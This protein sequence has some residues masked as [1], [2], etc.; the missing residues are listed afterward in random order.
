MKKIITTLLVAAML[1]SMAACGNNTNVNETATDS[2][3][4]E[5][6]GTEM[7]TEITGTESVS[8][9]SVPAEDGSF[10]LGDHT[11]G[12]YLLSEFQSLMSENPAMS[13]QEI[14]DALCASPAISLIGPVT[15]AMEEG[16]LPG[17]TTDITGF[18]E[19]IT[20]GPAISS[21]PFVGY[22]FDMSADADI[23]AF[24]TTLADNSD[25]AWQVCVMADELML[26]AVE[27]K[28]FFLMSPMSFE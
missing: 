25:L 16:Y 5:T 14:A 22:V 1:L 7:S 28:V 21:Q 6:V 12:S 2:A 10:D 15:M 3:S 18:E 13:A 11:V 23:D 17:F 19:C 27:D 9:E 8:T 24:M 4:T 26:T 20:F